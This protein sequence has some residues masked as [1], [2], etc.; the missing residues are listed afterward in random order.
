MA[1]RRSSSPKGFIPNFTSRTTVRVM[2]TTIGALAVYEF[3][4]SPLIARA[5]QSARNSGF[6]S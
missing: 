3:V 2:L 4:A 1:T 6:I 5:K